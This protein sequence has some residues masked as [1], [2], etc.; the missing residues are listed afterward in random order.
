M[1]Y[2]SI[3]YMGDSTFPSIGSLVKHT[4]TMATEGLII[5]EKAMSYRNRSSCL[6][7]TT[8][9]RVLWLNNK[10]LDTSWE[11]ADTLIDNYIIAEHSG[12]IKHE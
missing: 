6:V 8:T 2:D 5:D 12:G 3:Y 1:W 4:G 9:Y 7:P 11:R 10:E